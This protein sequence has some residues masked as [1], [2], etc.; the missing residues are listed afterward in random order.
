MITPRE[1]EFLLLVCDP[2]EYT[3]EQMADRMGIHR[4]SVDNHRIA[5]FEKF[6]IKSKTGLVLFALR[7]GL[8]PK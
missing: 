5:L 7:W 4:R 1:M 8:L 3:Y 6:D 2:A